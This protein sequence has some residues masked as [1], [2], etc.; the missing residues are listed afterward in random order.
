MAVEQSRKILLISNNKEKS[1][2]LKAAL[3][4][5]NLTVAD[6]HALLHRIPDLRAELQNASSTTFLRTEL[7][8]FIRETGFPY[9]IALDFRIDSGLPADLDP[10]HMKILRTMLI[11]YIILARGRG[12]EN[13]KGNFLFLGGPE[14]D[15]LLTSINKRPVEIL[16]LLST[17]DKVVNSFIGELKQNTTSFNRLFYIKAIEGSAPRE[18]FEIM[19]ES[20][21][22]ALSARDQ[23]QKTAQPARIIENGDHAPAEIVYRIS[24][25]ALYR[26][27][28]I[29]PVETRED[30]ELLINRFYVIGYWT[31]KTLME[32]ADKLI[33][34][35]QNGLDEDIIFEKEDTIVIDLSERCILDITTTASLAQMLS[36][37][38]LEYTEL[39][40]AVSKKNDQL[41]AQSKGYGLLKKSL[42]HV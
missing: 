40:V 15:E 37:E 36:K 39:R 38:F 33:A 12:F 6:N 11:S 29:L 3:A 30:R 22:Q 9:F 5:N 34:A 28:N 27:G 23:L 26:D 17:Q 21:I 1:D 14:K 10:D 7:L 32:V 31:N 35:I 16:N 19:A 13:I 18:K 8:K 41:L 25:H 24:D 42:I 20:Y 2:S 4:S